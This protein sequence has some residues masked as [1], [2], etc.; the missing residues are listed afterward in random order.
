MVL[1]KL[2]LSEKQFQNYF[3]KR[4]SVPVHIKTGTVL[5]NLREFAKNNDSNRKKT[6]F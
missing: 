6:I 5:E 1:M 3:L 2:F 4:H